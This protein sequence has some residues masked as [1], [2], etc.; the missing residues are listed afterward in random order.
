MPRP[1]QPLCSGLHI[2]CSLCLQPL[3]LIPHSHFWPILQVCCGDTHSRKPADPRARGR[4]SPES[5]Q[6]LWPLPSH[7]TSGMRELL[8]CLLP[9]QFQE[10]RDQGQFLV[11][12]PIP[13]QA[14]CLA[15]GACT[16]NTRSAF[17]SATTVLPPLCCPTLLPGSPDSLLQS[18]QSCIYNSQV[19]RA[20]L[21]SQ[22]HLILL[23]LLLEDF[24]SIRIDLHL[25]LLFQLAPQP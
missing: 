5:P 17:G 14:L 11:S 16:A 18:Q 24:V 4:A 22:P 15:H 20:Q 2:C 6:P 8:G 3:T 19:D 12:Q 25:P 9:C 1:Q 23:D 10:V 21:G 13:S 7:Y